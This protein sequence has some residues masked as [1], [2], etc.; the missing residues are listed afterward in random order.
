MSQKQSEILDDHVATAD[1]LPPEGRP[2]VLVVD[3]NETFLDVCTRIL[4]VMGYDVHR[5]YSGGETLDLARENS[6]RLILMDVKMPGLDGI[7]CLRRLK[8]EGYPAAVIMVSGAS[9]VSTVVEAMKAGASDFI[10]KP[11]HSAALITKIEALLQQQSQQPASKEAPSAPPTDSHLPIGIE[12][13]QDTQS[14]RRRGDRRRGGDRRLR[15]SDP[16]IAHIREH[17]AEIRERKDVAQA[18]DT[19]SEMVSERVQQSTG[20]FFRQFLHSC[21]IDAAKSLLET[22]DL[23]VAEVAAQTGFVTVQHF[24]RVFNNVVGLSP[25]KY[26]QQRAA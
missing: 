14:D 26:R 23:A 13:R 19:T 1:V 5:A 17:A 7:S 20:Q 11:F 4:S 10:T 15:E 3:D 8:A 22:T 12:R 18:L 21:R 6:Y 9:D 24:S 16:M 25:R 2:S